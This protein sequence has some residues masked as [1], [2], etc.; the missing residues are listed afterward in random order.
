MYS[1]G[2]NKFCQLGRRPLV[3]R[4]KEKKKRFSI[5]EDDFQEIGLVGGDLYRVKIKAIS[6]GWCHSMAV[7][8]SGLLFT[9]GLNVFG[10]LGIG[11]AED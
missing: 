3:N 7:T 8:M 9:W 2:Q 10:E 1:W 6:C 5:L 4:K 11:N